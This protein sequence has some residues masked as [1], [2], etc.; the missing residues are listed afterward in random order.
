MPRRAIGTS[1]DFSA[2]GTAAPP[3][4]SSTPSTA[5][6]RDDALA[7]LPV[8]AAQA[9]ARTPRTRS[10]L[11]PGAVPL[12]PRHDAAGVLGPLH[13][14]PHGGREALGGEAAP[15]GAR[16]SAVLR[17]PRLL[18]APA[19][20]LPP[21]RLLP[22][23]G[24]RDAADRSGRRLLRVWVRRRPDHGVAASPLSSL[25]LHAGRRPVAGARL[26]GLAVSRAP[27]RGGEGTRPR[28]R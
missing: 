10:G 22:F 13:D 26:R 27:E 23:R 20:V 6:R 8:P 12:L 18:G 1:S 16:L 5:W 14:R 7:R 3:V 9:G 21:P 4:G 25:A 17:R 2:S 15:D 11:V 24:G 19:D 28:V